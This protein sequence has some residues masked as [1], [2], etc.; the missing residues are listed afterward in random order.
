ML[1]PVIWL[2]HLFRP[3]W[4]MVC[5]CT[6]VQYQF[7]L[8]LICPITHLHLFSCKYR[9]RKTT[10][11][12][13]IL[14]CICVEKTHLQETILVSLLYINKIRVRFSSAFHFLTWNLLLKEF[15]L[16]LQTNQNKC[17]LILRAIAQY[18]ISYFSQKIFRPSDFQEM[19]PTCPFFSL[20]VFRLWLF[21]LIF[22]YLV[23]YF[24]CF[25]TKLSCVVILLEVSC[26]FSGYWS[27]GL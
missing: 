20:L 9:N 4:R 13:Q 24:W 25:K 23:I 1:S 18:C 8:G 7:E 15:N 17:L 26:T 12:Y 14:I 21:S 22:A 3:L 2:A 11:C 5:C 6:F 19:P 10:K 27:F 16:L